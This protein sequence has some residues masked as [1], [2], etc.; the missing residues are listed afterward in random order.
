[1]CSAGGNMNMSK[2]NTLFNLAKN[3]GKVKMD[4]E[5]VYYKCEP[6]N[7]TRVCIAMYKAI[8]LTELLGEILEEEFGG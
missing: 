8:E 7:V 2:K 4:L 5:D 1:M 3:I 6:K